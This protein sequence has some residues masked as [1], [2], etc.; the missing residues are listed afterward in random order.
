[1]RLPRWWSGGVAVR[2][3]TFE[4]GVLLL[5]LF[6]HHHLAVTRAVS[7]LR[8]TL[9]LR[10]AAAA[11]T[12]QSTTSTQSLKIHQQAAVPAIERLSSPERVVRG[13]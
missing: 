4:V 6:H 9:A 8:H 1:M 2:K 10:Q 12:I 13:G 3:L 7:A 5:R 11:A